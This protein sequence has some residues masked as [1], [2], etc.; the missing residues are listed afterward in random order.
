LRWGQPSSSWSPSGWGASQADLTRV[1]Q[2]LVA[3]VG[4]LGAGAIVQSGDHTRTKGLTTA[5]GIWITAA[6]G[7]AAGLGRGTT[8]L[9]TTGL[10]LIILALLPKSVARLNGKGNHAPPPPPAP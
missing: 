9:M 3:G 4:F 2:G 8:A 6:I 7:M 5:A 10:A 1:L